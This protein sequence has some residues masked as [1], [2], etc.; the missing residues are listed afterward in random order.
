VA[1]HA[2][3]AG[4]STQGGRRYGPPRAEG[5]PTA[6]A[7]PRRSRRPDSGCPRHQGGQMAFMPSGEEYALQVHPATPP[8]ASRATVVRKRATDA[9]GK[10][11]RSAS[12][13]AAPGRPLDPSS[14]PQA[15]TAVIPSCLVRLP[16]EA[17]AAKTRIHGRRS[18]K[19]CTSPQPAGAR[20]AP[21]GS[22]RR[23]RRGSAWHQ[24]A[25]TTSMRGCSSPSASSSTSSQTVSSPGQPG[26][27]GSR[28]RRR[29]R[30]RLR[31]ATSASAPPR[32]RAARSRTSQRRAGTA[33]AGRS[34]ARLADG[35]GRLRRTAGPGL[36]AVGQRGA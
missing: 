16:T 4:R 20:A 31:T 29:R 2:G 22:V 3:L 15:K 28:A 27:P 36:G 26:A 21:P 17:R 1:G 7:R 9:R 10:H 19:R 8:G 12:P 32:A 23:A 18:A 24:S 13:C 5:T 6:H 35:H 11:V 14:W 25:S 33:K 34:G 30:G